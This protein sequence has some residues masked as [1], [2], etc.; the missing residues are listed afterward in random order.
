[1]AE[2]PPRRQ[3]H[4]HGGDGH[5]R[6]AEDDGIVGQARRPHEHWQQ[7]GRPRLRAKAEVEW[8]IEQR[9]RHNQ[10]HRQQRR[11][12]PQPA[13]VPLS[14][15]QAQE[16]RPQDHKQVN[17]HVPRIQER[18][19]AQHHRREQPQRPADLADCARQQGRVSAGGWRVVSGYLFDYIF[20][21]LFRIPNS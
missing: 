13:R 11:P 7:E 6:Q 19:P 9:R 10:Q 14:M 20:W 3:G 5:Q 15:P 16:E 18:Q 2:A 17:Q 8:Q 12:P 21:P 1:M 4:E